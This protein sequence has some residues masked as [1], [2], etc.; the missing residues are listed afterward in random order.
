M[1]KVHQI[2]LL[3]NL[4]KVVHLVLAQQCDTTLKIS[5]R[6]LC[7]KPSQHETLLHQELSGLMYFLIGAVAKATAT[8]ITYPLQVVQSRLRVSKQN[9]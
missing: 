5:L 7:D 9:D 3:H 8:V 6:F 2:K 4:H 1:K